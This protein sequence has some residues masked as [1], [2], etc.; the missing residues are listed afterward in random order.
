MRKAPTVVSVDEGY[1]LWADTYD[2]T[3]NPLLALEQRIV[4]SLV[5]EV[6]G[7]RVLDLGCGTGRWLAALCDCDAAS[8]VG[9]DLSPEMLAR[10]RQK[11]GRQAELVRARCD[12]SPVPTA[13]ADVILCSFT[14]GYL[15]DLSSFAQ[16]VARVAAPGAS[17]LIS[18]VHPLAHDRGWRRSFR[19]REEEVEVRN[20]PRKIAEIEAEF[21][22]AGFH[23][24]A[25]IEPA[26]GEPERAV[27]DVAGKSEQ[28]AQ[29]AE[30]GPAIFVCRFVRTEPPHIS[31]ARERQGSLGLAG[32]RIALNA[33]ETAV[34]DLEV[35]AGRFRNICRRIR[36]VPSLDL[37]GFMVVP[38]LINAH[39]HLEFNLFPRLGKGPY[40]NFRKWAEAIYR[41]EESPVRE[42][43]AV[44]KWARL[45]WG[46]LKNLFSGVTTVCHHNPYEADAFRHFPVR[47]V[48]RYGWAH[49]L[50]LHGDVRAAYQAT[51]AD[52][53]VIIHLSEGPDKASETELYE[54]DRLGALRPNT[55]I[56]HAVGLSRRGHHLLRQRGASLVWCPSSNLFTLGTTVAI[57]E[58]H[59]HR[60]VAVGTDSAVSGAGDLLDELRV[61]LGLGMSADRLYE[62]ATVCP[63]E[64]LRIGN[65][66]G[67]LAD[68]GYADFLIVTDQG[69]TP[70]ETVCE[71]TSSDIE[72]VVVGGRPRLISEE[73]ASRWPV[74]VS[75]MQPLT[76]AGVHRLVDAPVADLVRAARKFLGP[77]L[78]LAG[79]LV[80]A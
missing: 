2:D 1:R 56:V 11:L 64:I 35:Q 33:R 76:I 37:H 71:M 60:R 80:T 74:P 70:A 57:R 5:G 7:K 36:G 67:A 42:H 31:P 45:W 47:V 43:C 15:P 10:A 3:P 19:W 6:R 25:L 12:R 4:K 21:V 20:Y 46:A 39:D 78:R 41:P 75:A 18:D 27:F 54:L 73:L 77:E 14:L 66:A 51:P 69:R 50:P 52:A 29:A 49:S 65:G 40:R 62:M 72:A 24:S 53:P 22:R 48:K 16:E 26:L 44:P 34:S 23:S 79:K 38:G 58:L 30:A 32:A 17:V 68:G 61:G 9:V 59:R 8:L 28:F 63:G 55:V 13:S